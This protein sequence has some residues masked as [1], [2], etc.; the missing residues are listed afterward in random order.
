MPEL[1][2]YK[3]RR[4]DPIQNPVTEVDLCCQVLTVIAIEHTRVV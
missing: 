2:A 3:I 4:K 1:G